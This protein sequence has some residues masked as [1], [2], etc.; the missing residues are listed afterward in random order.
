MNRVEIKEEAKKLAFNNKWYL[1]KPL[2]IV[3]LI[4]SLISGIC[5]GLVGND[6][7]TT[8]KIIVGL[9][10]TVLSLVECVFMV[11]YAHYVLEFVR[12]NRYEWKETIEFAKKHWQVSL[13]VSIIVGLIAAVGSILLV[14]PGIIAAIGLMFY[15]EVIVDNTDMPFMDII[16]KAWQITNG[17]KMELF[18]FLLSFIGWF[19]LIG[20]TFGIA[21]IW[22]AP[23][24][25][26]A[27]TLAYEK[28]RKTA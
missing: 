20:I 3:S 5:T 16:K 28:L 13:I 14:I 18:V 22:V 10:T 6:A 19:F 11:G 24:V 7:G 25:T 1:W 21:A 4:I 27:F 12:G 26:V 23:Y 2:V 8:S 9:V 15:Q 17:H